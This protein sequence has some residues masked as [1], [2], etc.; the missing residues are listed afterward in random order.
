MGGQQ[1]GQG[2][3]GHLRGVLLPAQADEGGWVV[4]R[5]QHEAA[6]PRRRRGGGE[7]QR[8]PAL[9]PAVVVGKEEQEEDEGQDAAHER[10]DHRAD[11]HLRDAGGRGGL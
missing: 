3:L 9:L 4:H 2:I 11:G 8:A 6:W 1:R 5:A 7:Q 10:E